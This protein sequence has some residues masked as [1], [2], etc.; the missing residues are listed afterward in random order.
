MEESFNNYRKYLIEKA[1]SSKELQN[2]GYFY[3]EKD[4]H[5]NQWYILHDIL[6]EHGLV[7][8][9]KL[10]YDG[11]AYGRTYYINGYREKRKI[12]LFEKIRNY[13]KK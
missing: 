8:T 10:E 6:N 9:Y 11:F 13:F 7:Y 2:L 12:S 1:N 4:K 3:M 5:E